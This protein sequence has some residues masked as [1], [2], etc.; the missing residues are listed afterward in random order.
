MKTE[1]SINKMKNKKSCDHT[2][3]QCKCCKSIGCKEND[4]LGQLILDS[5][6]P[7]NS[8]FEHGV[9][10]CL[11]CDSEGASDFEEITI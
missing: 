6:N 2:C 8:N 10:K 7:F 11:K 4:C 5:C 1:K 9:D 3:Y